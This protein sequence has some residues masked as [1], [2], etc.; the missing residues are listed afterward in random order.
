[1]QSKCPWY[2]NIKINGEEI[3][4]KIGTGV[5]VTE[6][7]TVPEAVNTPTDWCVPIVLISKKNNAV[8]MCV[9]YSEFNKYVS[10]Y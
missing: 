3:Q 4:L 5:D 6:V 1:M 2:T 7:K 8:T 9:D 10:K